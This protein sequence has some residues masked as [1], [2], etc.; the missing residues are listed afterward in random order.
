[1]KLTIKNNVRMLAA[2]L[3]GLWIEVQLQVDGFYYVSLE[4]N[5]QLLSMEV[6]H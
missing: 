3:N 4:H 1:M 2:L 6:S 5:S